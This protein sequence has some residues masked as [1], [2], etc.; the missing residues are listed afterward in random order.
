MNSINW[1]EIPVTDIDRAQ[2]FYSRLLARDLTRAPSN[3]EADFVMLPAGQGAEDVSGALVRG[4][5]TPSATGTMI[6]LA[7]QHAEGGLDGCLAR[8]VEAGGGVVVPRTDIGEHGFFGVIA[9]T[10]GN[11]VG[12]HAMS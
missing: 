10:E 12:L 9:D 4:H 2:A 11:H 1:F 3:G 7:A 8:A 5:G 6:Y